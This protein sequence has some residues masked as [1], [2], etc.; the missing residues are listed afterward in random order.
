[1][2]YFYIQQ[3]RRAALRRFGGAVVN[4]ESKTPARLI[5]SDVIYFAVGLLPSECLG[6][7]DSF[8]APHNMW[9]VGSDVE[10]NITL[11]K[12]IPPPSPPKNLY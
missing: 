7:T 1:M 8:T 6:F 11:R 3:S 4:L 10:L 9:S 2:W 12:K 5:W